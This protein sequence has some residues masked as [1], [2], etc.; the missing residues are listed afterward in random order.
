MVGWILLQGT[1]TKGTLAQEG[2]GAG[3]KCAT[4]DRTISVYKTLGK[5]SQHIPPNSTQLSIFKLFKLDMFSYRKTMER[6]SRSTILSIICQ[7]MS[8]IFQP[9]EAS[10]RWNSRSS[11]PIVRETC[12]TR[13]IEG[14]HMRHFRHFPTRYIHNTAFHKT[15]SKNHISFH[16]FQP[17]PS[18]GSITLRDEA[19]FP[20]KY[21]TPYFHTFPLSTHSTNLSC[22]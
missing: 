12:V 1:L 16:F 3:D 9:R 18:K 21:S 7:N 6:K 15:T 11:V 20:S 5:R 4:R 10:S 17:I 8:E 22:P 19:T 2:A 13:E 14:N